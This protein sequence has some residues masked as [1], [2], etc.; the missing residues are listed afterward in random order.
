[1]ILCD[2]SMRGVPVLVYANKMDLPNSMTVP[3]I[4]ESLGLT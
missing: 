2:E 1:M 4:S 3:Q